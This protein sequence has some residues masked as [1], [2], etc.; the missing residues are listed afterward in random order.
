[1]A[2]GIVITPS[3]NPSSDG[4]IKYNNLPHGGPDEDS[5]TKVIEQRSN[6]PY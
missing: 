2:D 6:E 4:G 5:I 3:H 1:L